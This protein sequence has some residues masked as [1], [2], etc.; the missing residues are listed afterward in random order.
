MVNGKL[1]PIRRSPLAGVTA[2][3]VPANRHWHRRPA[4]ASDPTQD[5]DRA[6]Q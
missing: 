6:I 4:I 1:W 3:A 2:Q 5:S